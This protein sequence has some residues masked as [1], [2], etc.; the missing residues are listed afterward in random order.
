MLETTPARVSA[1]A[2]ATRPD[3]Q[4][5]DEDLGWTPADLPRA[6]RSS[7]TFRIPVIVIAVAAAAA[8]YAGAWFALRLPAAQADAQRTA[9][10]AAL[11]EAGGALPGLSEAAAAVTDP[12][13]D[14]APFLP[15]LARAEGIAAGL[16]DLAEQRPW[17]VVPGLPAG[18]L[19]ALEPVRG[20]IDAIG[21][22]L[23]AVTAL[24]DDAAAYRRAL[25]DMFVIP[26]LPGDDEGPSVAVFSDRLSQM[27]AATVSAAGLLPPNEVFAGHREQVDGLLA[28]LPEWQAAYLDALRDDDLDTAAALRAEAVSRT[29]ALREGLTAPLASARQWADEQ[30]ASLQRDID[31]AMVLAG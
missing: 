11:E 24:L 5:P 20:R 10:A 12:A 7:R 31:A 6:V 23:T 15:A 18:D 3:E 28:W 14:P 4:I 1:P 9:Y 19:E 17:L 2:A 29:E 26:D 27:T 13:V 16:S 21:A 25:D 8:L 22:R 30:I